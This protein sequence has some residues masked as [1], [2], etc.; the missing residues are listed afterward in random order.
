MNVLKLVAVLWTGTI[1]GVLGKRGRLITRVHNSGRDNNNG[2]D[3]VLKS[4]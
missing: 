3:D 2:A 4:F 1:V